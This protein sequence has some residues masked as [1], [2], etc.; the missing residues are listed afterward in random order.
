MKDIY[1]F[2][3]LKNMSYNFVRGQEEYHM[4]RRCS[5]KASDSR[6]YTYISV[7]FHLYG[8]I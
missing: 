1:I 7:K 3:L 4:Y 6:F 8:I 5:L 2:Y